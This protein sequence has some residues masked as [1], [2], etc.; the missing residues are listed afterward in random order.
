MLHGRKHLNKKNTFL[1][2][3]FSASLV[4]FSD[5]KEPGPLF[6]LSSHLLV[7]SSFLPFANLA[8][9]CT[10]SSSQKVISSRE[11]FLAALGWGG[12]DAREP[13]GMWTVGDSP[14]VFLDFDV[15]RNWMP[16]VVA[17][18]ELQGQGEHFRDKSCHCHPV[19]AQVI[20][21]SAPLVLPGN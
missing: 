3:W 13:K 10:S 8:F 5:R 16:R 6:V 1:K 19:A 17:L 20:A 21:C 7:F 14:A 9:Y 15:L 2:S 12:P 11:A 18:T 4:S